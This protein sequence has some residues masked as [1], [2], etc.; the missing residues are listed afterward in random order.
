MEFSFKAAFAQIIGYAAQNTY[1]PSDGYIYM[2][3][4]GQPLGDLNPA[5]K[6][7]QQQGEHLVLAAPRRAKFTQLVLRL[8]AAGVQLQD[9]SGNRRI[10]AS[11]LGSAPVSGLRYSR[12]LFAAP[13]VSA[14]LRQRLYVYMQVDQLHQALAEL[15]LQ[16]DT[17]EHLYDY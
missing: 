11:L 15:Q 6:I 3:A 16:G 2:T 13:L 12:S 9:I 4:V 1:E 5:I 7:I 14:P 10:A 8:V 17:L